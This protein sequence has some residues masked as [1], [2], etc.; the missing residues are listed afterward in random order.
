MTTIYS[1]TYI[2][3]PV[4]QVWDLF[5]DPSRMG[6]WVQGFHS[7]ETLKGEGAEVGAMHL[8]T[9]MEGKRRI[10]VT[11]T[12]VS[13]EPY[14]EFAMDATTKGMDT[15]MRTEFIADGSG[16][17]IE[18]ENH[19]QPTA[20]FMRIMLPLM[21]GTIGKRVQADLDRFARLVESEA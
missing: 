12:V 19:F 20:L 7:I 2:N 3:R 9:F 14:K 8:L 6:E 4:E 1:S 13:C 11:E 5:Q 15:R 21:K 16:T 18:S 10:E 17:R